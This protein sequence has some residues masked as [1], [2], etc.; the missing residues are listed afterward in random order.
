M[1][2]I[3]EKVHK[4]YG[5]FKKRSLFQRD[6]AVTTAEKIVAS[7][8][9]GDGDGAADQMHNHLRLVTTELKQMI[10]DIR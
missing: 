5:N 10:P 2:N 3:V 7:I 1:K 8:K 9:T 4:A 6:T